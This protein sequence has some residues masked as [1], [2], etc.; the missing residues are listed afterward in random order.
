MS[1]TQDELAKIDG[2]GDVMSKD[3][4]EWVHSWYGATIL[5]SLISNRWHWTVETPVDT[6]DKALSG[7]TVCFTGKSERFSGDDVE[8]F[9]EENGAKCTHSVSKKMDYLIIGEKPGGSKVAKAQELG[10]EIIEED[11]FYQ[12]FKI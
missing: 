1:A 8:T 7:L 6:G 2:I 9:L 5:Q 4:Y 10:V 11:L 12:R 3:I